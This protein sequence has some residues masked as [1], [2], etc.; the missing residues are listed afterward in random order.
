MALIA[1]ENVK[2]KFRNEASQP[3]TPPDGFENDKLAT[4]WN[5]MA[6]K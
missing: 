3:H 6:T 1:K 2:L 5:G 4:M